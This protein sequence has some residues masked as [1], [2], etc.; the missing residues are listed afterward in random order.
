MTTPLAEPPLTAADLS[1]IRERVK[2]LPPA[3]KD[4][5]FWNDIRG[6]LAMVDYYRYLLE[7]HRRGKRGP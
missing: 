4:P 2:K 1:E 7:G 3:A 6:L 5:S